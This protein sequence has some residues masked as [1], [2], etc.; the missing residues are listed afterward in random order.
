MPT[1][2]NWKDTQQ[3]AI[4]AT[5]LAPSNDSEAAIFQ[6]LAPGTYTAILTDADGGSGVGLIEVYD[7]SAGGNSL[8]FN[9]STR[10]FVGVADHV[11]IGGF[12]A[13]GNN[14]RVVVRVLGPTLQGFGIAGLCPTRS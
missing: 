12:I 11:L 5:G 8:L 10:G 13:R 4:S 7:L 1:N 6:S 14:T 9:I 3:D 2:D